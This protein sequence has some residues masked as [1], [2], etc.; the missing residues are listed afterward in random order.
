M[1]SSDWDRYFEIIDNIS[2]GSR[3]IN[4]ERDAA[5]IVEV[6]DIIK[7]FR[8]ELP[9]VQANLKTAIIELQKAR[10]DYERPSNVQR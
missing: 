10:E 8:L 4:Y 2:D 5:L 3:V 7:K 9:V 1:T 6:G